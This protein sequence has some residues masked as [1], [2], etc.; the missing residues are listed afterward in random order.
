MEEIARLLALWRERDRP[1][2]EVQATAD[3]H[4]ADLE[5]RI[6]GLQALAEVLRGLSAACADGERPE[7]PILAE[8]DPPPTL[9]PDR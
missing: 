1:A 3:R 8:A 6:A 4:L 2:A 9:H 5:G 7:A